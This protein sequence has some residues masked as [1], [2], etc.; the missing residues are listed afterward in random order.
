M[1]S[2]SIAKDRELSQFHIPSETGVR[3]IT[4]RRGNRWIYAP[5]KGESLR[6]GD[7]V[8]GIGPKEGLDRLGEL[9]EGKRE[10][11]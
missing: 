5:G 10:V 7:M 4:I 6:P 9:L 3:I 8:I 2:E 1:S 11:L